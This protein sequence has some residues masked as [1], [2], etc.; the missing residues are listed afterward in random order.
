MK[1]R[2]SEMLSAEYRNAIIAGI[3]G[4]VVNAIVFY[5]IR[6][7]FSWTFLIFNVIVFPFALFIGLKM[8]ARKEENKRS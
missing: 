7:Q 2:R 8:R 3:C 1:R 5:I 4:G 6:G